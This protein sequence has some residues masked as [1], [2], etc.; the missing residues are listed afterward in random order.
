MKINFKGDIN[1]SLSKTII[2]IAIV[3]MALST[4][5][6][7]Y[8]VFEGVFMFNNTLPGNFF[9]YNGFLWIIMGPFALYGG[10]VGLKGSVSD[11]FDKDVREI[12]TTTYPDG[13][14]ETRD[15]GNGCFYQLFG[16][17]ITP[18]A[19]GAA[20]SALIYYIIYLLVNVFVWILPVLVV[21]L[22]IAV[23][24][25]IA[26]RMFA[27]RT[28][29]PVSVIITTCT[30]SVL[31]LAAIS[32]YSIMAIANREKEVERKIIE[33]AAMKV[34]TEVAEEAQRQVEREK[35]EV[36]SGYVALYSA[37][38]I[39]DRLL[40]AKKNLPKMVNWEEAIEGCNNYSEDNFPAG[41]WRLPT[42]E[43]LKLMSKFC[44]E[45]G[46]SKYKNRHNDSDWYWI[47]GNW[48][49][50]LRTHTDNEISGGPRSNKYSARCVRDIEI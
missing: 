25:F 27:A 44:D 49:V 41:S 4:L 31:F 10:W 35:A 12:E 43:E 42:H 29:K 3:L 16:I 14:T 13:R 38:F 48:I 7:V 30:L 20:F 32:I 17:I 45:L 23:T 33:V 5:I 1:E 8:G 28:E 22:M 50:R 36:I 47:E 40:V 39:D 9:E 18:I 21:A 34:A 6:V 15:T 26:W 2:I 37:R 24:V 46:I 11:F 19:C